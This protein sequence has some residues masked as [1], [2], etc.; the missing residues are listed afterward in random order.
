MAVTIG[1]SGNGLR[2]GG[3]MYSNEYHTPHIYGNPQGI[4]EVS[5][6]KKKT[7]KTSHTPPLGVAF[8]N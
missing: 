1:G 7:A 2:W 3:W 5:L 4:Y 8:N 6:A